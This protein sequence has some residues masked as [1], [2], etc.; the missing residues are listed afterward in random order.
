MQLWADRNTKW[1]F[2]GW[3]MP[4]TW[5]QAFNP[6]MIFIFAP[7]LP[8]FWGWQ[9]RRKKEPSSVTKMAIGCLLLG[10]S[11]IVMIV[12]SRGMAP[13]AQR[14]LMWLV[15][16]TLI[17]TIGELYLSPV[18]LSFVTKVAPARMVS[19]LMGVWFL[20]NF[21]GNYLS[22]YLG[23]FW[24]KIPREQFFT[25]MTVLGVAAGVLMFVIA[26]PLDRVV[27]K[28]DRGEA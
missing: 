4:S 19:M 9:A 13:D 17:L 7:V 27:A 16:T 1:N 2:F 18:G 12:A 8:I 25:L 11:Y 20:A 28:H 23:T 6:A 14:S 21:F 10:L 22:G 15:G 3:N 26:K 5:F 24:E